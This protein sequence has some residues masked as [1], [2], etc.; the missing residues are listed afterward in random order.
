MSWLWVMELGVVF[1]LVWGLVDVVD[2]KMGMRGWLFV[3]STLDV[4]L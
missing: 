1:W 2:W 4:W 3:R